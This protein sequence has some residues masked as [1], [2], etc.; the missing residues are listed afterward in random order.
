MSL[1]GKVALVTGAYRGIGLSIAHELATLGAKVAAC[2]IND[3]CVDKLTTFFHEKNLIGHGFRLDVTDVNS[4]DSA[5][6]E[7]TTLYGSPQILIN[8]A[9][10]TKDN[11][12]LRMSDEEWDKVIDTNLN[13]VFRLSRRVIRSMIKERWGRIVNIASV[14]GV[15]GN[16]GQANYA[17]SKAGVIAFSKSLAKEVASRGITVNVIAPGYIDTVMTQKLSNEQRERLLAMVPSGRYGQPEDIAK[18]V[19][20]LVSDNASYITG[21]TLHINGGMFMA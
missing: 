15:V 11:L 10:I 8:N 9:G 7:I 17:A 1:T 16:A 21:E 19:A 13:S 14:V 18:A 12:V 2:D 3:E 20:F 5:L 4:I 6:A